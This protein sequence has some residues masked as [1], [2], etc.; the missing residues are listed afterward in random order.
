MLR[1]TWDEDAPLSFIDSQLGRGVIGS[2]QSAVIMPRLTQVAV[3]NPETKAATLKVLPI[4]TISIS[5]QTE[6]TGGDGRVIRSDYQFNCIS[7]TVPRQ[8][9]LDRMG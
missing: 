6:M 9:R 2:N 8:H 1:L 3:L 5:R 4:F 7:L